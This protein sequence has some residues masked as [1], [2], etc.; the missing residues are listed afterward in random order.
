MLGTTDIPASRMLE[1][2][3]NGAEDDV[4]SCG[5]GYTRILALP[6]IAAFLYPWVGRSSRRLSCATRV[7][8]LPPG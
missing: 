8:P 7:H 1:Q 2:D 4:C 6:R 3:E 5:F